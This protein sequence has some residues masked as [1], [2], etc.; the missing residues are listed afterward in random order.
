MGGML[1][2]KDSVKYW[3]GE[4]NGGRRKPTDPKTDRAPSGIAQAVFKVLNE[5]PFSSTKDLAAQ[6]RTSREL[7]KRTLTTVSG[8]NKINLRP[9]PHELAIAQKGNELLNRRN[10]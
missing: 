6:F 2:Q 7:L 1:R 10:Y 4:Y 5:Q 3:I 8:M 9:V